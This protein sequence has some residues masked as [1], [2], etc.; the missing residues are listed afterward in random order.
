[1]SAA[2][3]KSLG[4]R[5]QRVRTVPGLGRDVSALV[6]LVV[7]GLVAAGVILAQINLTRRGRSGSPS[8]WSW[9]TRSRSAPATPRRCGI[10]GVE[11]GQIVDAGHRPQ[12]LAG[13]PGD[14]AGHPIYD[15]APRCCVGQPLNQM[16][17]TLNPGGPPGTRCPRA[18]SS[19]SPR[20]SRPIQPDEVFNKLDDP[21]PG[22]PDHLL[23]QSDA[24]LA[25]APE[26]L[27]V[28]LRAA[29]TSLLTLRPVVTRLQ[30]RA[31]TSASWS[32]RCPTCPVR[33]AATT[34][35]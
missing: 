12:H 14:R 17:I 1:M 27:P 19:R 31:R 7:V 2:T 24:A 4:Q 10:A 6:A 25:N 13:H 34:P 22:G 15:N 21:Q 8:R 28:G 29:D 33:W 3:R 20:T 32:P 5:W 30:T 18:A 23:E 35:G 11:V 9:P 26:T 16:Y